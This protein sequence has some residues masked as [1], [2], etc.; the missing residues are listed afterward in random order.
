MKRVVRVGIDARKIGDSGIGRY[1]RNLLRCLLELDRESH[2]VLYVGRAD[3]PAVNFDSSRVSLVVETAGK[4]GLKEHVSLPVKAM[5]ERVDLFHA[6][7]Y[8]LPAFLPC[9]SV[10]T[11]HDTIHLAAPPRKP[12]NAAYHYAKLVMGSAVRRARA[13]IVDSQYTKRDLTARFRVKETK[14]NVIPLGVD[15]V[16][17]PVPSDEVSAWLAAKGLPE[18]YVLYVGN[19]KPHKNLLRLVRAFEPV[20]ARTDCALVLSGRMEDYAK[21]VLR[22][23]A[24]LGLAERVRVMREVSDEALRYLYSGAAV[25]VL[26]SLLEG[27]GLSPLEAMACGAPVVVSDIPQL[28]ETIREYGVRVDPNSEQAIAEALL[29]LLCHEE[30]RQQYAVRGRECA[31]QFA[32]EV[33]ARKTL[34]VYRAAVRRWPPGSSRSW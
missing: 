25:F 6:P 31:R 3:L 24:R 16:F 22:E 26:P 10:V 17:Q 12:F 18:R 2:Y 33:T 14:V 7:H 21:A 28:R 15:P 27:F 23:V 9:P 30:R 5:R 4:Y 13:V 34:E 20:S 29:S 8:V 19:F 32:W 1:L 11:I